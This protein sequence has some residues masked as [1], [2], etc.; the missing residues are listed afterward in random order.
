[1]LN[2]KVVKVAEEGQGIR[3]TFEGD[4]ADKEQVFDRVL[5]AIGRRPNSK[6]PGSRDDPR[7][8]R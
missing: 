4:V 3:V 6:I 1:M 8:D 7:E 2:T 5:V